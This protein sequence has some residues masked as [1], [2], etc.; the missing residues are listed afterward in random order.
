MYDSSSTPAPFPESRFHGVEAGWV[1][2]EKATGAVWCETRD[3]RLAER[4]H[5]SPNCEAVPVPK[6]LCDLNAAIRRS[7]AND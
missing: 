3:R 2:R 6:Y 5:A 4:A 1:V 7:S